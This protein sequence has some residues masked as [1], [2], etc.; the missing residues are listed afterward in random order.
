MGPY[1]AS[2]VPTP[3]LNRLASQSLLV[4]RMVA[5]CP[6][7]PEAY[8]SYWQGRHAMCAPDPGQPTLAEICDAERVR[9]VLLSDDE[10]LFRHALARGFDRRHILAARGG[11]S[12]ADARQTCF[13]QTVI[14]CLP[15][16]E[17]LQPPFLLWIHL[18][19]MFGPWDA[20]REYRTRLADQSDP[21]PPGFV[22]PPT[23]MTSPETDPD[24]LWGVMVAY[25][26]QIMV[27][28]DCLVPL[29]ETLESRSDLGE[30]LL[31]LTSPRG[32]PLGEHGRIGPGPGPLFAEAIQVPLLIRAPGD[33]LALVR[34]P[35]L[36]QAP[37][38][39]GTLAAWFGLPVSRQSFGARSAL[40]P[41]CLQSDPISQ[42][43][44]SLSQDQ[45]SLWTPAWHLTVSAV[46][47]P[48]ARDQHKTRQQWEGPRLFVKPDDRWDYNEIGDR[49][50]EEVA[51]LLKA[52]DAFERAARG[53]CLDQLPQLPEPLR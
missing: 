5:D 43:A 9:S 35:S 16:I 29:L 20:P 46:T 41:D 38:V 14:Q 50:P 49:C 11:Q 7:L 48:S 26:A 53:G 25:A 45:R 15:E 39:F 4:E 1:G 36:V 3:T 2:W 42:Y 47:R 32:Y 40:D 13:G 33:A 30:S 34:T 17:E 44:A 27:L 37:S 28:D 18:R 23:E 51:L 8:V 22:D 31:L 24:Y 52:L 19:G 10:H 21:D 12:A 6:Q